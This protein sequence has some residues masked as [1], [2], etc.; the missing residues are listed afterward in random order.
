MKQIYIL[1]IFILSINK[2]NAQLND[3]VTT[4]LN[5]P[6]GIIFNG[7]DLYIAEYKGNKISKIDITAT[8]PTVTDVIAVNSA[9]GIILNGNDLYIAEYHG[10]KIS[11]IDIT[12]TNPVATDVVTGLNNPEGIV[13]N[14]NDLYISEFSG[15]KILKIDI[16]ET[17]P[18]ATDIITGLNNPSGLVFNGND[19]YI[20]E[21]SGNKISKYTNLTLAINNHSLENVKTLKVYPNPTTN[22]IK[23]TNLTKIENYVIYNVLGLEINRGVTSKD[24]KI[25]V[26][27][28]IDGIYLLKF[29][30][31]NILKFIK[32]KQQ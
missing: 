25:N 7:N 9:Y 24:E 16:T 2:I 5:T 3:V 12:A 29:E 4:G 13:L 6:N 15:N 27:N 14:G 8:N 20:S 28:L 11:K 10:N 31:S 21:F 22:F 26:Q 23:I 32:N 17:N 30:N 19:L 1:A 18:V